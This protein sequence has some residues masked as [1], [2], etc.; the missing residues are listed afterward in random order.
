MGAEDEEAEEGRRRVWPQIGRGAIIIVYFALLMDVTTAAIRIALFRSMVDA[1]EP[2]VSLVP[3]RIGQVSSISAAVETVMSPLSGALSDRFGRRNMMMVS[4]LGSSASAFILGSSRTFGE[5]IA[6][7]VVNSLSGSS[8]SVTQAFIADVTTQA[9]RPDYMVMITA[10]VGVAFTF[11]PIIGGRLNKEFGL[12]ATCYVSTSL[13]F[14]NFLLVMI[15]MK[16]SRK[17]PAAPQVTEPGQQG[18]QAAEG[19][20]SSGAQA[21]GSAEAA[22]DNAEPPKPTR[23]FSPIIW[24]LFTANM[25]VSPLSV[26]FEVC[27]NVFLTD[28]FCGGDRKEGAELFSKCYSCIGFSLLF[29]PLFAYKPLKKLVGFTGTIILGGVA[30]S[31]GL[32]LNA[33]APTPTLF[34]CGTML[35]AVGFQLLGPAVPVLLTQHA[36]PSAFGKA[37]GLYRSFGNMGRVIAPNI[38]TPIFA[39]NRQ[40]VFYFMACGVLIMS[41]ILYGVTV[42]PSMKK[43]AAEAEARDDAAEEDEFEKEP[44]RTSLNGRLFGRQ[45]SAA[46]DTDL[47]QFGNLEGQVLTLGSRKRAMRRSVSE[48]LPRSTRPMLMEQHGETEMSKTFH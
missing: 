43:S 28:K 45:A 15:F 29:I 12:R 46:S 40:A 3:M 41:S 13:A 6:G 26:V 11:G 37:F 20:Q 34:L 10:A 27:A 8:A 17:A 25:F 24:V 44:Q 31:L 35:W 33:A 22:G 16:E 21:Q 19:G 38:V 32:I 39:Y 36:A 9:E 14:I 7:R 48:D 30:G 23:Q 5:V 4:T 2:D 1:V 47:L 18:A 42:W